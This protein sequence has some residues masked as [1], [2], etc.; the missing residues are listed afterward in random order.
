[1]SNWAW[2]ATKSKGDGPDNSLDPCLIG[3][4]EQPSL[5]LL[6]LIARQA[7]VRLDLTCS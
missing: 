4:G 7:H 1:M 3:L 5:R 2:C 6:G